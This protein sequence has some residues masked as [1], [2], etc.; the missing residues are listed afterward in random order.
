MTYKEKAVEGR[1]ILHNIKDFIKDGHNH[2][3]QFYNAPQSIHEKICK[4]LGKT[5][6]E[7][8]ETVE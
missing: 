8:V 5:I 4:R 7:I 3:N 2:A 6:D 1:E